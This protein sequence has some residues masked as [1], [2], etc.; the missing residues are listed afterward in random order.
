MLRRD[1]GHAPGRCRGRGAGARQ[2]LRR[3]IG[4]RR[5][6]VDRRGGGLRRARAADRAG[7]P[8]GQGRERQPAAAGGPG[9]AVPA[10]ERGLGAQARCDRGPHRCPGRESRRSGGRR[11]P[12]LPGGRRA[13]LRLAPAEPRH[14]RCRS[15]LPAPLP[16]H[17]EPWRG[18]ARGRLGAVLRDARTPRGR[19]AGRVPGPG[20]L[21]L[22]RRDRLREAP[23]R[24]RLEHP[25]RPRRPRRAPRAARDRPLRRRAPRH[26]VPPRPRPVHAKAPRPRSGGDRPGSIG[27][28]LRAQG[29]GRPGPPGSRPGL[30]LAAREPRPPPG[31]GRGPA[32]GGGRLQRGPQPPPNVPETPP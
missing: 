1:Q 17:G 14:R 30:V 8:H 11:A 28:D 24:C 22:L 10:L 23:A 20:V 7:P 3:R 27:L 18:A 6:R 19:A 9:R 31:P 2:R 29:R 13:W 25:V 5:A 32:R 15:A 16:D 12:P 26:R 21:R 4:R